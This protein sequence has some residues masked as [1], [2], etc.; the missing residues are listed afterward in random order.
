[1]ET[2]KGYSVSNQPNFGNFLC[3]N[4]FYFAQKKKQ[5]LMKAKILNV[6]DAF[7]E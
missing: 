3:S 6:M 1:M 5:F 2:L 7:M 4:F